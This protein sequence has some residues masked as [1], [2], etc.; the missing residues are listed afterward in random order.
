MEIN[1]HYTPGP[2]KLGFGIYLL[3]EFVD[4]LLAIM[5]QQRHIKDY[6]D[7]E[8]N[9]NRTFKIWHH[10]VIIRFSNFAKRTLAFF[11]KKKKKIKTLFGL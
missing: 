8:C 3:F 7:H 11:S 4:I 6:D 9:L 1:S 2:Q 10:F 5:Q